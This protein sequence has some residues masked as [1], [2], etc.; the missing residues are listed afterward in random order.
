MINDPDLGITAPRKTQ[1]QLTKSC[2]LINHFQ[3]DI[4]QPDKH[5]TIQLLQIFLLQVFI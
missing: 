3:D 5:L 4:I 2:Q 1:A